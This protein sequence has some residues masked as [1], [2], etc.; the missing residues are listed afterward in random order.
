M[1]PTEHW[2]NSKLW[3][4]F[5]NQNITV[6]CLSSESDTLEIFHAQAGFIGSNEQASNIEGYKCQIQLAG[7][8]ED[9]NM[10]LSTS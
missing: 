8:G 6:S 4:W 5:H 9:E 1:V 10:F 7:A 2:R 3:G